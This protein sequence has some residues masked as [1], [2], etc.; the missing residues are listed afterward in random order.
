MVDGRPV[1]RGKKDKIMTLLI[2]GGGG[3]IMSNLA[4][5]WLEKN[6]GEQ[7]VILDAGSKDEA[8]ERFWAPVADR[9]RYVQGSVLD[10]E[11]I[12]QIAATESIDRIVH[13][14]TVT[15]FAPELPSGERVANPETDAPATVLE[16][17][18]MGTVRLLELARKLPQLKCFLNLSSG[19]VYNDYGPEPPGPMPE[20]GWVDPPEFYGIT[21]RASEMTATRYGQIFDFKVVSCRLSGVYGPMDRWRPSRAYHCPPYVAIHHGLAGKPVRINAPS[22]VG[23]HIH[24]QDVARGLISLLEK[25]GP[26]AHSVYNIAQGE[27]VTV[28]QLLEIAQGVVPGLTWEIADPADCDIVMDPTFL[29]GRWGAYDISRMADETGWRPRPVA[30]ALA[31]YADF[32]RE[33]GQTP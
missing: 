17:N 10:N 15:L 22:G 2:T 7:V 23:D 28:E 6:L 24:S 11:V 33:F 21:K 18:F 27:A 5:L 29:G 30:T 31:D 32:V 26:F 19:A 14:A 12:D 20:E 25:D 1:D 4:L 13:A 3:F 9:L 8:L 16:V